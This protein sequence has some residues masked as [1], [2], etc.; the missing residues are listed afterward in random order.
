MFGVAITSVPPTLGPTDRPS[1][2]FGY[3]EWL[4]NDRVAVFTP[5]VCNATRRPVVA[6][7]RDDAGQ[8]VQPVTFSLGTPERE[9]LSRDAKLRTP[10]INQRYAAMLRA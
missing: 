6:Y 8:L 5:E 9:L 10:L 3:S 4:S 7:A 1:E 2:R